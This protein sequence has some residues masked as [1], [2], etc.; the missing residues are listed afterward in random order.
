MRW[1]VGAALVAAT[2]GLGAVEARAQEAC[3]IPDE[4]PAALF[5]SDGGFSDTLGAGFPM[6]VA[7]CDK[8]V[9]TALKTC[10]KAVTGAAKC[11]QGVGKGLAKAGKTVCGEQGESEG[12]C[13]EFIE[14]EV[15][16]LAAAV[17]ASTLDGLAACETEAT[18]LRILCI[19]F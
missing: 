13:L 3:A 15:A 17:Q 19:G 14:G 2:L 18:G 4:V 6:P 11:W 9:K 16:G 10:Q 5:D 7:A 1:I 12:L 8:V